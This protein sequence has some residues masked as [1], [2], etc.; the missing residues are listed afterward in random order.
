M[1]RSQKKFH[2]ILNGLLFFV[3]KKDNPMSNSK[4]IITW[5]SELNLKVFCRQIHSSAA[6]KIR[7]FKLKSPFI[8]LEMSER[9]QWV[10]EKFLQGEQSWVS[11][12]MRNFPFQLRWWQM[13]TIAEFVWILRKNIS[14][15]PLAALSLF[16]I[17]KFSLH[18]T[19]S[20][21]MRSRID[22]ACRLASLA[23]KKKYFKNVNLDHKF[24]FADRLSSSASSSRFFSFFRFAFRARS[25]FSL[26]N[27]SRWEVLRSSTICLFV[28]RRIQRHAGKQN[29]ESMSDELDTLLG[30]TLI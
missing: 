23:K 1:S 26:L 21:V 12:A 8:G 13:A 6:I 7:N 22:S 17:F 16:R 2:L 5:K 25:H 27:P 29:D 14:A 24:P 9:W 11:G 20:F 3:A 19:R 10:R 28:Q 15:F 4:A 30:A 18:F